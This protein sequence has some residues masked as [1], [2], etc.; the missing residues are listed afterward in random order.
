M[1]GMNHVEG[2][3]VRVGRVALAAG[4]A[5]TAAHC[6]G[7]SQPAPTPVSS[8]VAAVASPSPSPS[9]APL[10]RLY[11]LVRRDANGPAGIQGYEVDNATGALKTLGRVQVDDAQSIAAPADG[12]VVYSVACSGNKRCWLST[13]TIDAAGK[14]TATGQTIRGTAQMFGSRA[15]GLSIL[16]DWDDSSTEHAD[17]VD[18]FRRDPSTG[19]LHRMGGAA[20]VGKY[21]SVPSMDAYGLSR[22]G[23]RAY[24][25]RSNGR[26]YTYAIDD[27]FSFVGETSGNDPFAIDVLVTS[28]G[29]YV[30]VLSCGNGSL[31]YLATY[32]S[33]GS[34]VPA[35]AGG[36]VVGAGASGLAQ[37]PDGRFLFVVT[38]TAIET[39]AFNTRSGQPSLRSSTPLKGDPGPAMV[40]GSGRFLYVSRYGD[41]DIFVYSIDPTSGEVR[42]GGPQGPGGLSLASV[43]APRP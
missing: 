37:T 26:M 35:F 18:L 27:G 31:Y 24:L 10:T 14:L 40:D 32:R 16:T 20:N 11:A 3:G 36:I 9:P 4:L 30:N 43:I 7:G 25:T 8:S 13:F 33:D 15:A 5:L 22:D 38:T 23:T 42:P 29:G 6:G 12:S 17:G 34:G 2:F 41:R 39:Y 28:D 1:L 19:A 21:Y